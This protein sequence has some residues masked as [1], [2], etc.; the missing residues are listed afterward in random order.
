MPG[1]IVVLGH[2]EVYTKIERNALFYK[3]W[4]DFA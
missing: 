1:R 3:I 2:R 4:V